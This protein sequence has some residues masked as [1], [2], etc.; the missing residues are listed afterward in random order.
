MS[1]DIL[2]FD[3]SK[4][5]TE[6]M[7]FLKWFYKK[8]EWNSDGDYNDV[9]GTSQSLV[10]FFMELV[11]EYPAMNGE[12]VPT[13]EKFENDPE[14]ESKL[15]D[16]TIDDDLIYMGIAYS[17][18][19][20]TFDKIEELAYKHGLGYYDMFNVHFDRETGVKIPQISRDELNSHDIKKNK[21][22]LSKLFGRK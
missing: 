8:S 4:V 5:P 12:F 18:S 11:K 7:E 3:K 15:I 9:K 20:N 19:D 21:G 10:D 17:V 16:Y 2:V 22:F 13:D 14:L 6:P 1:V